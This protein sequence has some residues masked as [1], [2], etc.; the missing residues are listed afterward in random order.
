MD[1]NSQDSDR[2]E[3]SEEVSFESEGIS[4]ISMKGEISKESEAILFP[5]YSISDYFRIVQALEDGENSS[6][7][8]VLLQ[9]I[10]RTNHEDQSA[11]TRLGRVYMRLKL[12]K[13][14]TNEFRSL[15][16]EMREASVLFD[17][18]ICFK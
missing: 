12:Y 11:N 15:R 14:A 5:N 4:S 1:I 3:E 17:M 10:R 7:A 8:M 13:L 6:M 18:G 2:E 9:D 16:P